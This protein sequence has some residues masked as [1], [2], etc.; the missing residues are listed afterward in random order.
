[1]SLAANSAQ[2]S[3]LSHGAVLLLAFGG[4]TSS[5]EVRP[6]IGRVLQGFPV[7]QE[8]LEEIA[9]HYEAVGGK[10]P[11]NTITL[12]QARDL[13]DHLRT[14][15][16]AVPVFVGLR[17]S[18]P[19]LK[20][21]LSLMADRRI[22]RAVGFILSPHQSEASWDRY[23]KSVQE[24][25]NELGDGAP[26]ITFSSGWHDHP[27]FIEAVV[28]RILTSWERIPVE[29]RR[30]TPLIFTAHSIPMAMAARG[31]Y[32]RQIVETSRLVAERLGHPR[33]WVAYQSRSGSP[34]EKWLEPDVRDLLR[35]LAAEQV[36]DVVVVPV[37]F[38]C[39]HVEILYDLD[40]DAR[41]V[42]E[43]LGM[44]FFRAPSVNDH[45]AFIRMMAEVVETTTRQKQ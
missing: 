34:Q 9:R 18:S 41:R 19:S 31:P 28:E 36:R 42:A 25:R 8:R 4:P 26:E 14:R 39:D 7:S 30:S 27:L 3:I 44:R 43:N 17:Y 11:L 45:P 35:S 32:V 38:I 33:W 23:I 10:S 20:E 16:Y 5:K 2:A 37:G 22:Q 15:G 1:M 12:G 40:I 21:T 6:F 13:E 24:A 29:R